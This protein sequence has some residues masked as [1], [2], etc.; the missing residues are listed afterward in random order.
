MTVRARLILTL[1]GIT[2]LLVVPA[3][4]GISQLAELRDIA[5]GMRGRHAAAFLALG[6]LQTRLAELDRFQRAYTAAPS[7]E[8]REQLQEALVRSRFQLTQLGDAGYAQTTA[9]AAA[10]MAELEQASAELQALV[11]AG[12]LEEA[13]THLETVRPLLLQ[14][15]GSLD[16]IAEAIDQRGAVDLENAQRIS[17]GAGTAT[18]MGLFV[19][20][21]LAAALGTWTTRALTTPLLRLRRETA[22]VAA[23]EFHV[24]EGLPY[25]QHDEIGDL[26]RSFRSMTE[27]LQELERLKAEFLGVA[28]HELRTP[29]NVIGGYAELLEDGLY[30]AVTEKQREALATIRD[31]ARVLS[32]LTTQLLDLSR[33]EAG[34]FRLELA[35]LAVHEVIDSLERTF[36]ALATQKGIELVIELDDTTPD[37][38]VADGERLRHEVLGNLLSNA[39]KFTPPG[40]RVL[41]RTA[42]EA[43][44]LRFDV[45]DSGPGIPADR[46]PHIFEKFYQVGRE[47]RA[48]GAGLGL[49][50]ARELVEAH[51]GSIAVQ[52]DP[53]TGTVF[54]VLVP[55]APPASA[56]VGS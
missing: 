45:H 52:S 26:S 11:E 48:Q 42:G 9:D 14:M 36:S 46:L 8:L 5:Y 38:I 22:A 34:G 30:G 55:A 28:T 41:V 12:R 27:Q 6:R 21:V 16:V 32:R 37:R 50:I 31:Q 25:G 4:Y 2:L 44:G 18:L 40:G 10:R 56:L 24:P 33:L 1:T 3:L 43:D 17:A 19:A 7:P 53:D 23:G 20:L 54:T 15:R 51:G 13:T 29:I 49:A 47:A 39:I 35:P